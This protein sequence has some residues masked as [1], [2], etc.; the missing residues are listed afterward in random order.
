MTLDDIL[1][2]RLR[3][4]TLSAPL[5]QAD[6]GQNLQNFSSLLQAEVPACWPPEH[7]EPHCFDFF[8]TQFTNHPHTRA[9]GRY[10]VLR[11]HPSVLIGTVGAFP[12]T[13][14][15]VEI[16]YGVLPPWQRQGYATEA[17]Q[18]MIAALLQGKTP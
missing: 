15:E 18:T 6:F 13:P 12:R 17:T 4:V 9:W 11:Q 14:T 2:T 5:L 3:L 16:G 8:Q 7:W 10:V 1:T